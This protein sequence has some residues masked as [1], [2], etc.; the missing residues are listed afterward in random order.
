MITT[1]EQDNILSCYEKPKDFSILSMY[2]NKSFYSWEYMNLSKKDL[3]NMYS[4]EE[5][6]NLYY[7]QFAD[8]DMF[9]L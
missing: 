7:E 4:I 8:L 9:K 5:I 2:D 6:E 1:V 3:I